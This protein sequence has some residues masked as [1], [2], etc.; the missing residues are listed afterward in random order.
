VR[1][2]LRWAANSLTF[3]LAMYLVDTLLAPRFFIEAVWIAVLLAI[4]L[5]LLISLIKPLHRRE[6]RPARA[7]GVAV[8]T[9]IGNALIIQL[10]IWMRAPLSTTGFHWVLVTAIF[11]ALLGGVINWL[12]GFKPPKQADLITKELRS[13]REAR[14]RG[15]TPPPTKR[16]P[17]S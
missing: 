16:S 14:E 9:V 5:A 8:A 15:E 6:D 11:L 3:Y 4:L 13:S 12:I 17:V 7:W 1:F 10:F 2:V